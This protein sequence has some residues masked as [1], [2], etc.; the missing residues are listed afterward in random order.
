MYALT[1]Y[2]LYFVCIDERLYG[3]NQKSKIYVLFF[4]VDV[5]LT[6]ERKEYAVPQGESLSTAI[7]RPYTVPQHIPLAILK[8]RCSV[9]GKVQ[10][11]GSA[12]RIH[13]RI[14]TGEKPFKCSICDKAW[15]QKNNYTQHMRIVHNQF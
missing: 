15:A 9:C 5:H 12:L 6:G 3:M 1:A 8:Y 7:Q 13:M 4:L 11:S 2:L 14:H 10:S